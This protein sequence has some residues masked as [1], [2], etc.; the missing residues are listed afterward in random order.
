[1]LVTT[2]ALLGV[3]AQA[4]GQAL[5]RRAGA[6]TQALNEPIVK[7]DG[8]IDRHGYSVARCQHRRSGVLASRPQERERDDGDAILAPICLRA[9]SDDDPV[10]H[11]VTELLLEPRQVSGFATG[12]A[13]GQLDRDGH[14]AAARTSR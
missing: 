9:G 10:E 11:T 14:D 7:A 4:V 12:N 6:E 2:G 3:A 13:P 1:M 8:D 5:A